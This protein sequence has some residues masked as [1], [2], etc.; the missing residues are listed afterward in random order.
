MRVGFVARKGN[1]T[2]SST[3]AGLWGYSVQRLTTTLYDRLIKKASRDIYIEKVELGKGGSTF[4][5]RATLFTELISRDMRGY[6]IIHAPTPLPLKPL[7][8]S[9]N[10]KLITTSH[11]MHS[12]DK[13]GECYKVERINW[14]VTES[15]MGWFGE[16]ATLASDYIIAVSS[17]TKKRAIDLGFDPKR[18]FV[19]NNGLDDRF[20]KTPI[21]RRKSRKRFVVGYLG[22]LYMRKNVVFAIDAFKKIRGD[23]IRFE[24][25]GRK[26]YEY[27]RL[28]RAAKPDRRIRFMGTAPENKLISVYDSFD[29]FVYPTLCDQ[30]PGSIVEAQSR[31]LPVITYK[32]GEFSG[33]SRRYCIDANDEIHMADIIERLKNDGSDDRRR[34]R[35]TQYA[36]SFTA[37][38][39]AVET[40]NVYEKIYKTD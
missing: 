31:G 21:R 16:G 26:A 19:V 23:D 29:V 22:P 20:I 6:D 18:I 25:W 34:R 14:N 2:V 1:I 5:R 17:L 11:G 13:R 24:I 39:Q 35:A 4:S 30:F 33:E 37:D 28:V 7:R 32:R 40:L 10:T 38:R 8:I 36:R 12:I 27:P 3:A 15:I 9:Q